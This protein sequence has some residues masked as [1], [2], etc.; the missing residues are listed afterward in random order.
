[1]NP[2]AVLAFLR[3]QLR[4]QEISLAALLAA[5]ALRMFPLQ[6]HVTMARFQHY[7][8]CLYVWSLGFFLQVIWSWRSLTIRGRASLLA[9]G[10]Y[11]GLF[12]IIFYQSPWLDVRMAVQTEE[13]DYLRIFY[14][15]L[16]A[17]LGFVVFVLWLAWI[18]ERK[19]CLDKEKET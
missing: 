2:R 8:L 13:E 17:F 15:L 12:G 9:T 11:I 14:I 10:F 16:C 1:M 5:F 6:H 3:R 4:N 18:L 7:G 19:G